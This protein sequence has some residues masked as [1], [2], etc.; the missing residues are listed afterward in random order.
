MFNPTNGVAGAVAAGAAFMTEIDILAKRKGAQLLK[1]R[2]HVSDTE[3][4]LTPVRKQRLDETC[5]TL[6]AS[7]LDLN[8]MLGWKGS[9]RVS[10]PVRFYSPANGVYHATTY[11]HLIGIPRAYDDVMV[12]APEDACLFLTESASGGECFE[13]YCV[14]KQVRPRVSRNY[15]LDGKYYTDSTDIILTGLSQI[16]G[17][18]TT[19]MRSGQGHWIAGP[20]GAKKVH[21][22][23]PVYKRRSVHLYG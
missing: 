13:Q 6:G 16:G 17:Q 10:G 22:L 9:V 18:P 23:H 7:R 5:A 11:G 1:V 12:N 2:I 21:S 8:I 4:N 15:S 19:Y 3:I 14:F 20:C